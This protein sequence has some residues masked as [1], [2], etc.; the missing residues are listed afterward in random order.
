VLQRDLS[1][2]SGLQEQSEGHGLTTTVAV[3]IERKRI[4]LPSGDSMISGYIL[5]LEKK[6]EKKILAGEGNFL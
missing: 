6:K 2:L 4:S 1:R 5:S 3:Y